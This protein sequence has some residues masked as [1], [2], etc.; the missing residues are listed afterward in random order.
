MSALAKLK[1]TNAT[2]PTHIPPNIQR[3]HKLLKRLHEQLELARAEAAGTSYVVK[4]MRKVKDAE[5]GQTRTVETPKRLKSWWFVA[6][7]GKLCVQLRYGTK[8]VEL[9]KGKSAVEVGSNAELV[10]VMETLKAAVEAGELDGQI[11]VAHQ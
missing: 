5:T 7:N 9:A 6:E 11:G 4:R 1:L 8:V 3:R 10:S 2:K